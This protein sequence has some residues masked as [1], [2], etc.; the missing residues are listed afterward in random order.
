[1]TIYRTVIGVILNAGALYAVT[2]FVDGVVYTGGIGFFIFGGILIGLL[3]L[4]VKP[5]IKVLSLP[6]IFITGGLFL[7]VINA[8]LLWFLS[9][10]LDVIQFRDV[11]LL[12][13]N[14]G[15]YA[16]GAVVFGI[17]NWLEHLLLKKRN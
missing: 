11:S 3:N 9:Y 13:P 5:V 14:L 7:I 16:I 6:F 2:E 8:G 10:F 15:S 12:F 1:M 17:I 4:I